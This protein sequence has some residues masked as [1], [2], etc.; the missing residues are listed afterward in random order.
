MHYTIPTIL[1]YTNYTILILC[2]TIPYYYYYDYDYDYDYYTILY[3]TI[4]YYTILYYRPHSCPSQEIMSL[5]FL[6][7]GVFNK[8]M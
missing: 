7:I 6:L 1:Y 2:Y 8:S 5:A 4:L 3:Y